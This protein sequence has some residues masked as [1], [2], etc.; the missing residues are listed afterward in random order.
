M[1]L[2]PNTTLQNGKYK[3]VRTLG[4]GGFGITYEAEQV[5]L[6]RR[7][8][9]KEFF[10]K[11]C[12][13][14]DDATSRV[15][16][17]TGSQRELVEK[18]RGKFIREAQMMAGMDHPNVVR[19]LDVFE[20]NGTAYYVMENL[21][22]GSLKAKVEAHGPL[23]EADAE[24]YI[25]A[26]ADALAYIHSLNTVHLDVK[27]SNILL[28]SRGEAVLIDFGISKHYDSAGEQ[29]SSTPVGISKGYAP[30]EQGR[31]GDVSQFRPST[32]IYSLGATLYYLVSGETPPEASVAA[33]DGIPRPVGVS[34]R[35]WQAI[36]QSMKPFRRNRPQDI[37]AFLALLTPVKKAESLKPEPPKAKTD[38]D[39]ETTV[40]G[41]SH[42]P[43]HG[44]L[45]GHEWVD[46]GLPSGLK[47]ATYNVGASAPEEPGSYFAWGE[48]E[49]KALY[50]W[51]TYKFQL[52]TN[53][54]G[55]IKRLSKYVT[56]TRLGVVDGK[57][58]LEPEDD[59][60]TVQWG[61][62]WRLPTRKEQDEL[63]TNCTW[64]LTK[65][66]GKNGYK[67]TSNTNGNSIF[68]PAAECL[69]GASLSGD[70]FRGYYLSSSLNSDDPYYAYILFFNSIY[71]DWYRG[72]RY[73]GFSVRP[74]TE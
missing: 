65:L 28:N 54:L 49:P 30:L 20:E 4:Q 32:D 34:D 59:A 51:T 40:K 18:F 10:M 42:G 14:R 73:F 39:D 35:I 5:M 7:V 2:K 66:R 8:A 33:E 55:K 60:A 58:R 1:Q 12:C 37:P 62:R 27:P 56:S 69:N 6:R 22:G 48:T 15:T 25:R 71:T 43:G 46:L 70:G 67:V 72:G 11:D 16:V 50:N 61:E 53:W 63:R 13:E 3:I 17:G 31:D 68:L 24:K 47:W 26:V 23:S 36:D 9:L 19:V 21:A 44:S 57:E 41:A 74:V 52:E 29:T 38:S 45:N 64:T